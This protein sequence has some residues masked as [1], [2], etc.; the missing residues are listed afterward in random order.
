MVTGADDNV[1]LPLVEAVHKE[2]GQR[3]HLSTV[4]RWALQGARGVYLETKMLG[5][6]R[7]TSQKMVR[8]FIDKK[9]KTVD[10]HRGNT[11]KSLSSKGRAKSIQRANELLDA[12]GV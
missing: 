9:T 10:G 1:L 11:S 8:D 3:V 4:L 5:G 12:E 6:R 7:M 2:T